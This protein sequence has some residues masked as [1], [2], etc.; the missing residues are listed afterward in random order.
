MSFWGRTI[1]RKAFTEN[2]GYEKIKN[3]FAQSN[4]S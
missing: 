4:I 1:L 2:K 3:D